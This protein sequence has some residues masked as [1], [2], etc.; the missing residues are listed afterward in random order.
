MKTKKDGSPWVRCREIGN[1]GRASSPPRYP[2]RLFS[3][4]DKELYLC[5]EIRRERV[6]STQETLSNTLA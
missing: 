1:L 6:A 5:R 4:Q 2:S 3:I